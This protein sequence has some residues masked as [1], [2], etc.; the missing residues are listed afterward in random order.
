MNIERIIICT[1]F[2]STYYIFM[3][4]RMLI[5]P[6]KCAPEIVVYSDEIVVMMKGNI[7]IIHKKSTI[8]NVRGFYFT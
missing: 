5:I 8:S 1:Y 2:I 7:H 3:I 4:Y 6:E